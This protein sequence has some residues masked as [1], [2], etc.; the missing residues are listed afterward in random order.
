MTRASVAA[1]LRVRDPGGYALHRG[2]RVAVVMPA[3]LAFALFV[4]GNP[5][6]ATFAAFGS[7][8]QL[9]FVDFPG[10]R[11][12]RLGGYAMLAVAGAVLITVGT[13][14][15]RPGWVAVLG[16]AVVGFVVL[17][18]GVLSA[19]IAAAGRA[20]LLTF[21]LPV[22]LAAGPA[23]IPPRLAGW[24]LAVAA[25]VPTALFMW[26]PRQHDEL[27]DRASRTCATL[28]ALM[29]GRAR[30]CAA[31]LRGPPDPATNPRTAMRSSL[32]ALRQSFRA[33]TY[34][35]VGLTMGTRMLVRLVDELEWLVSITASAPLDVAAGLRP[36][37][38]QLGVA[39]VDVLMAS[40][41][42]L[43]PGSSVP[44]EERRQQLARA[45]GRLAA[46]RR[47]F[48]TQAMAAFV[49]SATQPGRPAGD[50]HD[51]GAAEVSRLQGWHR[52]S[53]ATALVGRTVNAIAA[54]DARSL[55][56]R[57][58]GRP[59]DG[60]RGE[61]AAAGTIAAGHLHRHS[62]WLQNSVRGAAGLTLA[63]GV[64][65]A[66]GLQY[67]FWAVLGAM[68]V[69]R[70]NALSTGS[71][72]L[73]A[74]A[75][76]VIGFAIGAALVLIL[77]T[78]PDVLWPLLPVAVFIAGFAPDAV[79]FA[80]GQAAFT[81]VIIILYNIIHPTGWTVGLLRI[82]D[83]ALGCAASLAVGLLFWPRG[84]S[85]DLNVALADGFRSRADY[86]ADS[87]DYLSRDG[88]APVAY[89]ARATAADLRID[90]AFRQYIAERGAKHM[91]LSGV[92]LLVNG[93]TRLRLTA[94]AIADLSDGRG[95]DG[96]PAAQWPP[97]AG[98]V[99]DEARELR[100]WYT[101]LAASLSAASPVPAMDA[102]PGLSTDRVTSLLAGEAAPAAD[103]A[104]LSDLRLLLWSSG[105]IDDAAQLRA[106]L[107]S[108]VGEVSA[109]H[110]RPWWQ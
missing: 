69:L 42:V 71:T 97:L 15:S 81:I 40:A 34:R 98:A 103:G 29:T 44:A 89:A 86:L 48:A 82:T 7:F 108:P 70:S 17:F 22:T 14:L 13:L 26:P 11:S 33:T 27:R 94:D 66:T 4:V 30:H 95:S 72:A 9:L 36:A 62:V 104:Q 61:L 77:G 6:V 51:H 93:A 2:L 50:S 88:P 68:S 73:R 106:S 101:Q 100:L 20:A 76:T 3:L 74:L 35:P 21:I 16:M 79:S 84:A 59:P 24:G 28:A 83:V 67:G 37:T 32:A 57:L 54:A 110:N 18:A 12:A 91:P 102:T 1:A 105:Y 64:A 41:S 85:A 45:M 31:G 46:G 52:L 47:S 10:S 99:Q 75:G 23:D 90:D 65:E 92:T 19:A 96:P 53:H 63:V 58:T 109:L 25:A 87:I 39:A 38:G 49:P 56:A 78:N 80:A 107:V 55:L 43:E 8:A 60:S 5:R